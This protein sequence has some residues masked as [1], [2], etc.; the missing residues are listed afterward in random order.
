MLSCHYLDIDIDKKNT[1]GI[2]K[3]EWKPIDAV[4]FGQ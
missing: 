2:Y 1:K 3:Q 4:D